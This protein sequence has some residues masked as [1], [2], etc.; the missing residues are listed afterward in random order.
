MDAGSSSLDVNVLTPTF[1]R[2]DFLCRRDLWALIRFGTSIFWRQN[3]LV[4][5]RFDAKALALRY[6]DAMIICSETCRYKYTFTLVLWRD[7]SFNRAAQNSSEI[8]L[9]LIEVSYNAHR[10]LKDL[11][12]TGTH[13]FFILTLLIRTVGVMSKHTSLNSML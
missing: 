9:L 1:W 7:N 2:L 5:R 6:L 10:R 13:T 3:V 4:W 8:W 11:V 12:T